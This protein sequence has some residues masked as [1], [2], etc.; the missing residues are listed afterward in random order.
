[1]AARV[2]EIKGLSAHG[3]Q[4]D[5]LNWLSELKTKPLKVFVVHGENQP[6]DELRTKIMEHY[7]FDCSIPLLGQEFEL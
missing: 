2:I 7:G 4:K 6:A 3:D 1:V 5:L